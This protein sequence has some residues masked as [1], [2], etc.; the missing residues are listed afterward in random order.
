MPETSNL[1]LEEIGE[2][3]GDE[4]VV[5]LTKDGHGIVESE[6]PEVQHFEIG[7]HE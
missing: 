3:F 6:K 7:K 5:H 4:V 1:S 2:L